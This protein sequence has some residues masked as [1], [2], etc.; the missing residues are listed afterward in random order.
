MFLFCFII[1]G[2]SKSI[3]DAFVKLTMLP[4][5]QWLNVAFILGQEVVLFSGQ[6]EQKSL[7]KK[8]KI[9]GN[10]SGIHGVALTST[11]LFPDRNGIWKCW[12]L[13]REENRSTRRKTLGVETRTNNKLNLH[14]TPR[15]E[16]DPG[17]IGG[18]RALS[19]LRHPCSLKIQ[20][21][22]V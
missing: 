6:S 5:T 21:S 15:P 10:F 19:P 12:F 7:Y 1:W 14:M 17:H 4:V 2:H 13:R 8:N 16:S 20:R 18:R 3:L 11:R 22:G 9:N